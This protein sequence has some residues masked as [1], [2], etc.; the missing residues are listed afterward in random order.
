MGELTT[1]EW[2]KMGQRGD[3]AGLERAW[4]A[5]EAPEGGNLDAANQRGETCLHYAAAHGQLAV[6]QWLVAQGA[7]VDAKQSGG[8][9]ALH[10]AVSMGHLDVRYPPPPPRPPPPGRDRGVK[11]WGHLGMSSSRGGCLGWGREGGAQAG[12]GARPRAGDGSP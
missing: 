5:G 1:R 2:C 12:P 3:V 6:A 7:D 8:A 4:A 11:G 10:I 9:S